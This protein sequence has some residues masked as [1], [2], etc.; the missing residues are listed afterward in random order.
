M[1]ACDFSI[2]QVVVVGVDV[3]Q[4]T[5]DTLGVVPEAVVGVILRLVKT[6]VMVSCY[7]SFAPNSSPPFLRSG[8][9]YF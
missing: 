3:P 4:R 7:T 8:S 1:G 5:G 9:Q 2:K 6:L